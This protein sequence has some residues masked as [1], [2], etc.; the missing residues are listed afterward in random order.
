MASS[1]Q[2]R[3]LDKA[4]RKL[5]EINPKLEREAK[6]RLRGDVKPIVDSARGTIPSAAPLS[7]WVAPK[8]G[9]T[10]DG[11]IVRSGSKRLPVWESGPARR[12]IGATVAR[13]KRRGY[14]GRM[15]L[16]AVRQNDAAGAVFDIAGRKNPGSQFARNLESAGYGTPS[17]GMWPA[18]ENHKDAVRDSIKASVREVERQINR[19]LRSL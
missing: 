8:G 9:G 11:K 19:E 1:T 5:K 7:R 15:L 16:V 6:K 13:K 14:D 10:F 12:R 4:L 2:I 17:R 3:N 18:A